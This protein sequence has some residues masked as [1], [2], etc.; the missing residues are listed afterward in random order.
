VVPRH[1]Y[2]EA[3]IRRGLELREQGHTWERAAEG[4]T[5]EG[6]V[7]QSVLKRWSRRFRLLHGGLVGANPPAALLAGDRHSAMLFE[8]VG[9]RSPDLRHEDHW[10][11]GPPRSLD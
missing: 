10:E 1:R 7:E 11:R 6:Q 5:A 4:C 8:P 2:A 9:N 3:V